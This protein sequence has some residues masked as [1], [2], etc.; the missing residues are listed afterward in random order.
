MLQF[1]AQALFL[2]VVIA[3]SGGIGL[4]DVRTGMLSQAI[5][6]V[7]IFIGFFFG[8]KVLPSRP[9]RHELPDHHNIWTEGFKEVWRTAKSINRYVCRIPSVFS[10]IPLVSSLSTV[11]ILTHT[12]THHTFLSFTATTLMA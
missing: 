12:Y 3:L 11:A 2:I 5:N 1:S 10:F 4:D 6:V 9:S 7:W 8:W